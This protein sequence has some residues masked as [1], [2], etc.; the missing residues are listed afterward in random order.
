L[1]STGSIA[2]PYENLQLREELLRELEETLEEIEHD[3]P[4]LT[5]TE[6]R[7]KYK[8][9]L[10]FIDL[11]RKE[12][13]GK[14]I[15]KEKKVLGR[16]VVVT[17]LSDRSAKEIMEDYKSLQEIERD[18]RVLKQVLNLRPVSH[19]KDQRVVSHI[20]ICVLTLLLKHIMEEELGKDRLEEIMKI[21]SY[22]ITTRKETFRWAEE[23]PI[24]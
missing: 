16:W 6:I 3:L 18:F 12:L 19:W 15:E 11:K 4:R 8:H 24:G 14:I 2:I 7:K 1:W 10:K 13:K 21:F 9:A 20:F 22:D 23:V 5:P 17:N